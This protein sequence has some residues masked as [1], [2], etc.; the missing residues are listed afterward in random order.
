MSVFQ[1]LTFF[2]IWSVI[3]DV[4][5][6]ASKVERKWPLSV[7]NWKSIVAFKSFALFVKKRKFWLSGASG[8]GFDGW[9]PF[10]YQKSFLTVSTDSTI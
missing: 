3:F 5:D 10:F 7:Y 6:E 2:F 9:L 1:R 4:T 8:P